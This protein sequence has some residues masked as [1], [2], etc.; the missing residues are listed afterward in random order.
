MNAKK[1]SMQEGVINQ[2]KINIC[3]DIQIR[4]MDI[5]KFNHKLLITIIKFNI[6]QYD[7]M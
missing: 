3:L 1:K 2:S 7:I 4:I 6:N 5:R